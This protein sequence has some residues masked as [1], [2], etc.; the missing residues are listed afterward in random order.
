MTTD[1]TR[2]GTILWPLPPCQQ[3]RLLGLDRGCHSYSAESVFDVVFLD[4][5]T[6]GCFPSKFGNIKL[7]CCLEEITGFADGAPI[8][9][10]DSQEIA[11]TAFTRFFMPNGLPRLVIVDEGSPFKGYLLGMCRLLEI[12]CTAVSPNNHR[13]NRLE[14]FSSV[15]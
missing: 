6:P 12:P 9:K 13:A 15:P 4:V 3:Q 1:I 2:M 5:W 7:L 14:R 11:G 10:E 8:H